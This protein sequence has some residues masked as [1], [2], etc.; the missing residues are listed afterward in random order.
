MF[1]ILLPFKF[2]TK[3]FLNTSSPCFFIKLEEDLKIISSKA[4]KFIFSPPNL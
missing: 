3:F 4:F 1:S 2:E